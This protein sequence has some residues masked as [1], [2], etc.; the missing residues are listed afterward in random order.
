MNAKKIYIMG[1]PGSGKTS[2]AKKIC[3]RTKLKN[4][5]LDDIKYRKDK[6]KPISRKRRNRKLQAILKH[7]NWI[8]EGSYA[9]PWIAPAIKKADLVVILKMPFL[10]TAKRIF[11]RYLKRKL[12]LD[13]TKKGAGTFADLKKLLG[14]ART[15]EENYFIKHKRLAKKYKKPCVIISSTNELNHFIK[16][17]K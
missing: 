16:E 4:Y 2:F 3:E 8:I 11:L 7:E 1:P 13:K 15:Y 6:Y 12:Y 14:Y 5:D 17:I 10:T 9:S